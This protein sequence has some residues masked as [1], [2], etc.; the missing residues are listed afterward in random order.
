MLLPNYPIAKRTCAPPAASAV[1]TARSIRTSVAATC[2]CGGGCFEFGLRI[3]Q[4][5]WP[6]LQL[7][8]PAAG[9]RLMRRPMREFERR[10]RELL[11]DNKNDGTPL[12]RRA[13]PCP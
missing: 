3:R 6:A 1:A 13:S 5:R 12:P 7:H 10:V 9:A 11:Y 4:D 2:T 8:V